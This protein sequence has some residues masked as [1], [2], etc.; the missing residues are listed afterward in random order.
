MI[1]QKYIQ[2]K[3]LE[4]KSEKDKNVCCIQQTSNI[5]FFPVCE[6]IAISVFGPLSVIRGKDNIV[7]AAHNNNDAIMK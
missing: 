2:L 5:A 1:Q 3:L 7:K 4:R 6:G